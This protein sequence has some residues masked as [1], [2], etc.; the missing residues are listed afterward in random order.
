MILKKSILTASVL[1]KEVLR[2]EIFGERNQGIPANAVTY[3]GIPITYGGEY[4]VYTEP[5][6]DF[7]NPANSQY[8]SLL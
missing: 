1:S 8:I 6:L 3:G 2:K 7:S 4:V 5:S